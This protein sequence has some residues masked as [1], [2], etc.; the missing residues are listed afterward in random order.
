MN[1]E[2]KTIAKAVKDVVIKEKG[3]RFISFAFPVKH[4]DEVK[5][6]LDEIRRLH[7]TATHHCYAYRL[8]FSGK[9]YRANDN[10][11]P[12]G[13]AGLPIYNQL[14]SNDLTFI[15]VIVVRYYGGT[16]LGVSGLIKAYKQG[17][18]A[19]LAEVKVVTRE[20]KERFSLFFPYS[21]QNDAMRLIERY[22]GDLITQTYMDECVFEIEIP[23]RNSKEF[24]GQLHAFPDI[25]FKSEK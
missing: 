25:E 23:K 1:F 10:G 11:E 4:E 2:C 22:D 3:S 8:G 18:E 13:T 6:R 17:A 19:V 14:L 9:R 24:S 5:R 16:K 21:S 15:L 12:S 7:P 20:K